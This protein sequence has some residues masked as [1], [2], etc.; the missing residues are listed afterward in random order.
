VVGYGEIDPSVP[1]PAVYETIELVFEVDRVGGDPFRDFLQFE[2]SKD[3]ERYEVDGFYDGHSSDGDRLYKV[4]FM[5]TE[6]GTWHYE[7][8]LGDER[9]SKDL[10][11]EARRDIHNQGHVH[12]SDGALWHDFGSLHYWF[13]GKSFTAN[14]YGPFSKGGEDNTIP[15]EA[16]PYDHRYSDVQVGGYLDMMETHGHNGTRLEIA[17]YPLQADGFGWDL[18][19]IHRAEDWIRMMQERHIYCQVTL[20][21]AH[22]R[23]LDRWFEGFDDPR[24]HVFNAWEEDEDEES[25]QAKQKENYIRTIVA[26]FSGFWN[27]YWELV[28]D[29]DR[30]GSEA[31]DQFVA[32][33]QQYLKWL[34]DYD[35]YDLATGASASS[36][37]Q[38][39]ETAI[40]FLRT[41]ELQ[42]DGAPARAVLWN[43][44]VADC[45]AEDGAKPGNSDATIRDAAYRHCYRFAVWRAFVTGTFGASSASW[46]DL[47]HP[48]SANVPPV[49][50]VM[51]DH[52]KLRRTVLTDLLD[53]L[54]MGIDELKPDPA[55]VSPTED[56][57]TLN[58]VGTRAKP[59]RVYVSYFSPG[60][61]GD[62]ISLRLPTGNYS[63]RWVNPRDIKQGEFEDHANEQPA[64]DEGPTK[65]EVESDSDLV[66]IDRPFY[67]DDLVLVVQPPSDGIE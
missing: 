3:G 6:P 27:V 23:R 30:P 4:R 47:N 43:E 56:G 5:V 11:V 65:L 53:L 12:A 44:M 24:K 61:G 14:N 46:L 32:A 35:P 42:T 21:D 58:F 49:I 15:P 2:F 18:E 48:A 22:S 36:Q 62:Q 60:G 39:N 7:W 41:E 64:K 40:D 55:F 13:G 54:K 20:F 38:W 50:K 29:V 45:D 37:V 52:D 17:L 34:D 16:R 28:S 31:A 19:W 25:E 67:D 33:S 8:N 59:G 51:R 57:Q 9:G 10:V 1:K 63:Y 26:R 66:T